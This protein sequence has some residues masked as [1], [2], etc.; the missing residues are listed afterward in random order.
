MPGA[1]R[2]QCDDSHAVERLTSGLGGDGGV[3]GGYL[4]SNDGRVRNRDSGRRPIREVPMTESAAGITDVVDILTTDH[5]NVLDL[6]DSISSAPSPDESRDI[7]DTVI[8]EI[9]RH[10]VAE[11]MYVYPAM[12]NHLPDGEAQVQHDI[13]EHQE[14][15]ETLKKLEHTSAEDTE[16]IALVAEVRSQLSHHASDEENSQFPLLREHIPHDEL[17]ELGRK[18]ELAKQIAPTRPHPNSPHS[19]LFHKAFGPGVGLVDKLRDAVT[20]RATN[21]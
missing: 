14:L 11:E 15:E 18:V 4:I 21:T 7:A 9:V 13:E 20:G 8:A 2:H 10:S 19:E 5:R 16:F 12:K 3:A 6:I 1:D 17:V